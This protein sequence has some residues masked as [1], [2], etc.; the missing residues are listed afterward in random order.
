MNLVFNLGLRLGIVFAKVSIKLSLGLDFVTFLQE[1]TGPEAPG[2]IVVIADSIRH[3]LLL[4]QLPFSE[5]H[6]MLLLANRTLGPQARRY[7]LPGNELPKSDA[8]IEKRANTLCK[9]L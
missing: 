1:H 4:S 2:T 8:L 7:G 6:S 3:L 9:I 5:R